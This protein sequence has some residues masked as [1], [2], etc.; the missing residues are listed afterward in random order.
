MIG[1]A[2]LNFMIGVALFFII[3]SIPLDFFLASTIG[4]ASTTI[5]DAALY[6]VLASAAFMMVFYKEFY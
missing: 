1:K 6:I 2:N 3:L 5:V 4:V